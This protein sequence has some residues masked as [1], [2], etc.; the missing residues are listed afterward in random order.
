MRPRM[1]LVGV[2]VL[3]TVLAAGSV[4]ATTITVTS[5]VDDTAV[6][7]NCTLR[8]AVIA[9]DTD[10]RGGRRYPERRHPAPAGQLGR[11]QRRRQRRWGDREHG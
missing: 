6:N 1:S 9:A 8:E 7:G 5:T 11:R 10:T 2:P 4:R 3:T